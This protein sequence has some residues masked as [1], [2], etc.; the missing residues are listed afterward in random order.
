MKLKFVSIFGIFFILYGLCSYYVGLRGYQAFVVLFASSRL[1]IY[2]AI[3]VSLLAFSFPLSHLTG[4]CLP[5]RFN[6]ALNFISAY[7]L[8]S[9]YYLIL[10]FLIGDL[11]RLVVRRSEILPAFLRGHYPLVIL[12]ILFTVVLL[13]IYGTW[14]ARHPVVRNY[15]V[16]LP[17]KASVM[18]EMRVVVVS[19]V[20]LGWIVGID[21]L[22]QMTGLINSLQPDLILL[23]G[24]I[25]DEGVDLAAEKELPAVLLTLQPRL[26][27]YAVMGNHEYISGNAEAAIDS[28]GR[29]G[30]T[31][32]RDQAVAI[33]DS[34]YLIG[35]DDAS[36]HHFYGLK[37]LALS[38]IMAGIDIERLPLILMDHEPANLGEA[39]AAGVDLQFSG[40]THRGQ[41][42]PNNYITAAIFEQDWGYLRK[43]NF[44]LI[45]SCGYGTWGPPIRIG[46]RPEILNVKVTFAAP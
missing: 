2:W 3:A 32:L 19:D 33:A 45:V 27:T 28:L 26:G 44:Q 22:Q 5:H 6:K 25:I 7:W 16:T 23:A 12:G 18:D 4:R 40:H 11:I 37:R 21:R 13:L 17:Q 24:D 39:E 38:D 41:L 31:V 34:F 10:I 29:A 9:F 46:S 30:I 1:A 20:H 14:N 36:R 15:E 35:R 8:A 42:F 43:N